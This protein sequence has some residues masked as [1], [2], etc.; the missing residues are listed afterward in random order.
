MRYVRVL[1]ADVRGDAPSGS[2]ALCHRRQHRVIKSRVAHVGLLRE[3]VAAL[4]EQRCL[5]VE[6]GPGD[7]GVEVVR[8]GR[9]IVADEL[10][11]VGWRASDDGVHPDRQPRIAGLPEAR[12]QPVIEGRDD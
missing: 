2:I 8:P 1:A 7:P 4:A 10:T 9:R 6:N 12:R 5:G 3:Q 11:P